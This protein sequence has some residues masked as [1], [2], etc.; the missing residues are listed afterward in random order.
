MG[1][2]NATTLTL[3]SWNVNGIRAAYKKGFADWLATTQPDVLALQETKLQQHQ[4]TAEMLA[5]AHGY[6]THWSHA[7]RPGYSGTAIYT[8][9]QPLNVQTGFG[10]PEFDSEGRTVIAEYDTFILFNHYYPNGTSGELRLQYKLD[11]YKAWLAQ[12]QAY[13][14]TGKALIVTGDF[15]TAHHEIDLARPAENVNESG[16]MPIERAWMDELVA[17]GFTDTFRY[18]HPDDKDRYTWWHMR[19]RARARNVGWRIDYFFISTPHVDRIVAADILHEVEGSD[20]CPVLLTIT[21]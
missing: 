2:T 20:H 18:L 5:P 14:A 17:D 7:E 13:K 6:S 3:L 4:L 11:F 10:I 15:N 21:V 1:D 19:T 12:V 8:K 16:F 9:P